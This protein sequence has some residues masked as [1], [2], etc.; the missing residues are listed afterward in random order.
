MIINPLTQLFVQALEFETSFCN[1]V[2]FAQQ[3]KA[4]AMKSSNKTTMQ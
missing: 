3:H 4:K 1:L 2:M